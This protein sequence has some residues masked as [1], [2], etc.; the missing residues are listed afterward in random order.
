MA[1]APAPDPE[2]GWYFEAA[3]HGRLEI[4]RCRACGTWIHYPQPRCPV[5]RGDDVAPAAVR[6]TGT[7]VSHT[8]THFP[9][10]PDFGG[11]LP[12]T[13]VMVELD[14]QPGLRVVTNLVD[15]S[16][17]DVQIGRRVEVCFEHHD[18]W[19]VPQFRP[20]SAS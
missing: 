5:C 1:V 3:R 18:T 8:V 14:E 17:D 12:I 13:L 15:A 7:V 4:L 10:S 11:E 19:S 6:G 2:T 9:P 16:P 20:I